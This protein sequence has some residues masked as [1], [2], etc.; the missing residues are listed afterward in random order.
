MTNAEY[1]KRLRDIA[2]ANGL[3]RGCRKRAPRPNLRTCD[4]CLA[5]TKAW[6]TRRE[7]SERRR[8]QNAASTARARLRARADLMRWAD[9]GGR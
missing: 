4:T 5:A 2:E 7:N 8:A 9:D 6:S 3:C 1:I